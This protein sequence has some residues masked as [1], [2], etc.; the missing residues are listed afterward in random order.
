[1]KWTLNP[2]FDTLEPDHTHIHTASII[3]L[4]SFYVYKHVYCIWEIVNTPSLN[5]CITPCLPFPPPSSGL[6]A[7]LHPGWHC[8]LHH[9]QSE[10][11]SPPMCHSNLSLSNHGDP[12]RHAKCSFSVLPEAQRW[13]GKRA[14]Q[15]QARRFL[16]ESQL[17]TRHLVLFCFFIK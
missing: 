3:N 14:G 8:S 17:K 15:L 12:A 1:M 10:T 4:L 9:S 6:P 7:N 5:N 13:A 16:A 11:P 2:V